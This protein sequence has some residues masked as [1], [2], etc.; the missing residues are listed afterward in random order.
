MPET[1]FQGSK[2]HSS[3]FS[4]LVLCPSVEVPSV[5]LPERSVLGSAV[6]FTLRQVSGPLGSGGVGRREGGLG[7][8]ASLGFPG[9]SDFTPTQLLGSHLSS[10]V[11]LR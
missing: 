3:D 5:D 2:S 4:R 11:R 6:A 10:P 1:G 9:V 7:G 8:D